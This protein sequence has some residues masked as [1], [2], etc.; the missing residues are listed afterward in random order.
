MKNLILYTTVLVFSSTLSALPQRITIDPEKRKRVVKE[1]LAGDLGLLGE[2]EIL[3]YGASDFYKLLDRVITYPKNDGG[4]KLS[5]V[6]SAM[7]NRNSGKDLWA[8]KSAYHVSVNLVI[9]YKKKKDIENMKEFI[10]FFDTLIELANGED[11]AV[12]DNAHSILL[13]YSAY[14]KED[15]TKSWYLNNFYTKTELGSL[16][17]EYRQ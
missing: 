3:L 8:R 5:D 1:L 14:L 13:E 4:K 7:D 17:S 2:P 15:L 12:A 9:S 6:A 16:L 10:K 11:L